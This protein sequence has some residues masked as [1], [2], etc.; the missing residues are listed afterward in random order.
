MPTS[1][2]FQRLRTTL[3]SRQGDLALAI[4]LTL[5][6]QYEIWRSDGYR[7][8][9]WVNATVVGA[10]SIA[11]VW[12]RQAPL[13][14]LGIVMGGLGLLSLLFGSS[15]TGSLLLI[16]IVAVYSAAAHSAHLFAAAGIAWAG[17]L[18]HDLLD[19]AVDSLG[20]ALYSSF[21]F[22]LVFLVGLAMRVRQ[23][24][25]ERAEARVET[26]ESESERQRLAAAAERRRIAHELHDVV[27]H[28][29]GVM[30]LQA[31]AAEQV[32]DTS[33]DKARLALRA[34]RQ[35]GQ[36]AIDEMAR[37]L[38]LIRDESAPTLEPYPR[39]A[40]LDS[41][42]QQAR[43]TGLDVD[44]G[45]EGRPRHLP[46]ALELSAYRVVQEGLTNVLKHA[47][48]TKAHVVVRYAENEL[49]V[50]VADDGSASANGPGGGNGLMGMRERVAVF[51]G[52]LEAGRGPNGGWT[53]RA[54]MP[55]ER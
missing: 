14:V 13:L 25:S 29:L 54:V 52:N 22:A 4:A 55:V 44:L 12:R 23:R 15:E 46:A 27:S 24:R 50:E 9:T 1:G 17:A 47:G 34:I 53:L 45:V 32:L 18:A 21:A 35:S 33:P 41:L 28:S 8:T 2:V 5:L 31:G 30:V 37:L 3:G 20:E 38:G 40:D 11:L 42:I 19:P 48:A 10:M 49:A 43:R 26:L 16:G 51:G 39:L 7:G 36:E 6:A